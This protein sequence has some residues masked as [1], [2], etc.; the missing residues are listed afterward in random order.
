M[1]RPDRYRVAARFYDVLS[2]EPAYRAGRRIGIEQ[3]ALEP[4]DT[5]V[6]IGCGTGPNFAL[7]QDRIGPTG[8]LLG[9]DASREARPGALRV[10]RWRRPRH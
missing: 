6:D 2:T 8:L 7:I 5:V 10:R 1:N 9:V 4:G 3:L